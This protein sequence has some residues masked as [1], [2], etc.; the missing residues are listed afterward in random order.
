MLKFNK[1]EVELFFYNE[2]LS[3]FSKEAQPGLIRTFDKNIY[4]IEIII[5][6]LN[7]AGKTENPTIIDFGCGLG[8]NL[9]IL[10]KYFNCKCIGL[11]RYDEFDEIHAREV[12]TTNQVVSR[13]QQFGVEVIP[14]NPIT[15]KFEN[16]IA[17]VV[18]SFDVIEHFN[19]PPNEYLANM[20]NAVRTG[21]HIMVGTPNQAHIF[22]RIKLLFGRNV[23]EDFDYW[24]NYNPF[25]GHVREL[26]T[27]ELK[28]V[29]ESMGLKH[30]TIH[31]SSYPLYSR[32]KMKFPRPI[33]NVFYNIGK[34]IFLLFPNLNYYNLIAARKK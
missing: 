25:Y 30:Y 9:M 26:L 14:S 27:W 29:I 2:I 15:Y 19:F 23:W 21:G 6:I 32:L 31:Q 28:K 18:T 5:K 4:E 8:I 20:I 33:A 3:S 34:V 13:L 11:D 1:K 10:S 7:N 24:M 17:D 16:E 12:G 22:N